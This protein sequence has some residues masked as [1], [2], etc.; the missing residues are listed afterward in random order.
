MNCEIIIKEMMEYAINSMT[1]E[2]QKHFRNTM[3]SAVGDLDML[4]LLDDKD[5]R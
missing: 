5:W 1:L 3:F 4:I 2:E